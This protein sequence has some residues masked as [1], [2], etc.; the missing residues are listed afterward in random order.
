MAMKTFD[1]TKTS[2]KMIELVER[3]PI[4]AE[5]FQQTGCHLFDNHY[6]TQSPNV[7]QFVS[8]FEQLIAEIT[9]VGTLLVFAVLID[10]DVDRAPGTYQK[11]DVF[12]IRMSVAAQIWF[13]SDSRTQSH[14]V[15]DLSGLMHVREIKCM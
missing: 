10:D 1:Y 4:Q 3:I 12:R 6:T 13:E 9:R 11:I 5:R 8:I 7:L 2:A 15:I 14:I